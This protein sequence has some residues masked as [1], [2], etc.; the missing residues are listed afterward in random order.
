MTFLDKLE[1]KFRFLTI[2]NLP[3]YMVVGQA[4]MFGVFYLSGK[5]EPE[6]RYEVAFIFA[7][8]IDL[9]PWRIVSFILV[10]KTFSLV[11]IVFALFVFQLMGNSLEHQ[12]GSFRFTIYVFISILSVLV[13]GMI[14]P[15]VLISNLYMLASITFAFAY[16]FPNFEFLL[17]F[18]LPVKVK[19]IGWM[20]FGYIVFSILGSHDVSGVVVPLV[21]LVNFPLFFGA[22]IVR[23]LKAKK[24]V[25]KMKA[26]K[27]QY[28]SEAFHKCEKC[29]A[30]DLTHPEREFRYGRDGGIC[31]DCSEES[32]EPS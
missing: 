22:D 25:S 28:E 14:F 1:K 3:L 19:W 17:F 30:T 21:C 4:L 12:W 29:G 32:Q 27:K 26:A 15:K 13:A 7:R 8:F 31:S 9:E 16:L 20:T 5:S 24:R 11:W 23:S 2:H 18:V 6:F 10:P